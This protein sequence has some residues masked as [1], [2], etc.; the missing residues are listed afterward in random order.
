ML[1]AT[2]NSVM[3]ALLALSAPP[4]WAQQRP[5]PPGNFDQVA[6]RAEQA[7]SANRIEEAIELYRK[8]LSLRSRWA[9]G[10]WYLGALL[11]DRDA[12]ADAAVALSKA[13]ALN[14]KVGTAWV[15][16]GLCEFKLGRFN[17]ALTHIRQGRKL[18]AS[19]DPQFKQVTLYHEGV[20]LIGK[21]DFEQAQETLGQL[22]RDGVEN[23]DVINALGLSV[24]RINFSDLIAGDSTLRQLAQ[25]AGLAEHLAAQKKFDEALGEYER[26]VAD[27]PTKPNVQYAF[28]RYLLTSRDEER[29]VVAFQHEIENNPTHLPAHLLLANTKLS[30]KDFDGGIPYAEKAVKLNSQSALGHYILGSLLLETDQ[31]ARAITELE[32]AGRLQPNE[33]K[34]YFML[35]RAY[36]RDNRQKD[37]AA[38]RA[39][40]MRLT[41]QAD[42]DKGGAGAQQAQ[43]APSDSSDQTRP[44][45]SKGAAKGAKRKP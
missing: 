24:L 27:F 25:R 16:L 4:S 3:V 10:W 37:A 44:S 34:I 30:L 2:L 11:Y 32:T 9:E 1:K 38:A 42:V 13:T 45:L 5:T 20:L 40:F 15:M 8:G 29:A 6:A 41:K 12:F 36:A 17:E 28:G 19:A 31:T 26:L 23:E 39:T 14:P 33:A 18:G 21:G 43:S 7:R 35:G 22:S